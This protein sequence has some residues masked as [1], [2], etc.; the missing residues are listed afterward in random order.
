MLRKTIG[1]LEIKHKN[2]YI[3]N[4]GPYTIYIQIKWLYYTTQCLNFMKSVTNL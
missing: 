2:E 3:S 1:L 4:I